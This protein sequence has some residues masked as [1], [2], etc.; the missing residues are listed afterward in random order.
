M[1]SYVIPRRG[2]VPQSEIDREELLVPTFEIASNPSISLADIRARRFHIVDR[3]QV[4][5]H[6]PETGVL[7]FRPTKRNWSI[8]RYRLVTRAR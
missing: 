5:R 7:I 2:Q 3:A 4:V 6:A 8:G 1:R